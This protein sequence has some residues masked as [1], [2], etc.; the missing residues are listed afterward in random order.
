MTPPERRWT[1]R[2]PW[3]RRPDRE[4]LLRRANQR[5]ES[6]HARRTLDLAAVVAQVNA[7]DLA[8]RVTVI[9]E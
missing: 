6:H 1:R 5:G 9:G 4:L 8:R 2:L 3:A 7:D